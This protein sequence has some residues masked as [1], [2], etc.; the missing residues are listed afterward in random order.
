MDIHLDDPFSLLLIFLLA[1]LAAV[2]VLFGLLL[3]QRI[4]GTLWAQ[5]AQRREA[6][7][8]PLLFAALANPGDVQP[9]MR[10]VKRSDRLIVRD[11]IL[12]L[13]LE[14]MG[15]EVKTLAGLYRDLSLLRRDTTGLRARRWTRRA[16][17]VARLGA[18]R[19][20]EV[21]PVLRAALSDPV[22][23]VRLAALR[24]VGETADREALTALVSLLGDPSPG[25]TRAT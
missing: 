3:L 14:L 10:T 11:M 16:A 19:S 20:L 13:A 2:L 23:G 8:T 25:V 21:L 12:R 6:A 7:L 4:V 17:A 22:V 15:D 5:H 18:L 24:A 1:L 9:L